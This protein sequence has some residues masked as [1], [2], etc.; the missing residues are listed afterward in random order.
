MHIPEWLNTND[1][2]AER[3][4]FRSPMGL[5]HLLASEIR[6]YLP[7]VQLH[8]S[9]R[10][11]W[12][13][14]DPATGSLQKELLAIREADDV[15]RYLGCCQGVDRTRPSLELLTNC[16]QQK[17]LP[18]LSAYQDQSYCRITLSFVGKRNY[19]RYFVENKLNALLEQYTRLKVLSNE[20]KE[21]KENGELRLRCHIEEDTAFWGIGLQDTPLHRRH[22]RHLRYDG[23]LH[24]TVAA[25]MARLL[26]R[27][28]A[29]TIID[30][31]C[32]SGTLLIES[33][34]LSPSHTHLGFDISREA[35]DTARQSAGMAGVQVVFGEK[36]SLDAEPSDEPFLLLSN[37]P[38]DEKHQIDPEKRL[39]FIQQLMKLVYASKGGVLLLPEEIAAELERTEDLQMHR[40]AQTRIRGKLAWLLSW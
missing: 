36:D 37:P 34:M 28:K 26:D 8:T 12:I 2:A 13:V 15:Y 10:N 40:L 30:P 18:L 29:N 23:Q 35:I 9:H 33:A 7:A 6:E 27:Q 24:T 22:W 3:Y 31:F 4:W 14:C 19:S 16:F 38:W 5:E 1:Y 17:I 39:T 21:A 32:G 25:A 11:V 20:L